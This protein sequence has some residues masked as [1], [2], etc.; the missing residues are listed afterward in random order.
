MH[1]RKGPVFVEMPLD[2]QGAQVDEAK[3]TKQIS[4]RQ[5]R[6]EP[7]A[8]DAVASIVEKLRRAKRP[9]ILLGAGV[10]RATTDELMGSS[11]RW[12]FR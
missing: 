11:R 7:V 4:S 2:V 1:G 9:V 3:L 12:A 6:F 5:T 8:D 10:E